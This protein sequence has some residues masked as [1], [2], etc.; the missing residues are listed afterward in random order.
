LYNTLAFSASLY[1][2]ENWTIKARDARR[3][4]ARVKYI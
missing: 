1:A 4:A 2:S 3:T